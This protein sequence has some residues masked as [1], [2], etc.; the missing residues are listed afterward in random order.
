MSGFV[1]PR[2]VEEL[3]SRN[4]EGEQEIQCQS[5]IDILSTKAN[6]AAGENWDQYTAPEW[7]RVH[8]ISAAARFLSNPEAFQ[9][10][11]AG[12]ESVTISGVGRAFTPE[13]SREEKND[14]EDHKSNQSSIAVMNMTI[15]GSPSRLRRCDSIYRP[16]PPLNWQLWR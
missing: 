2:R 12:Q 15:Y 8:V 3:L 10:S 4:L 16:D 7:A 1:E 14:F 6:H 5:A 9:K 11:S 13:F